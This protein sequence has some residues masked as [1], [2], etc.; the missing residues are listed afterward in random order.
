M[1]NHRLETRRLAAL[2]LALSIGAAA[3][4]AQTPAFTYQ[5]KLTDGGNPA[6]GTF[7]LQF[8][9]FDALNGGAQQGVTLTR[10]DVIVTSGVFTVQLDFGAAAFPGA[11]RFLEIGVRPGASTGAFTVLTPRQ[12]VL[13]TPYALR[14]LTAGSADALAVTCIGCVTGTQIG[15]GSGN[16][17]QNT[18]TPQPGSDFNIS[19]TGT[20]N[21]FNATTQFNLNN[22]RVL[23][24]AGTANLFVGAGAGVVNTSGASNTFVGANAGANNT[25]GNLNTFFGRSVG[26]SNTSGASNSFFASSAGTANTTGR[27]GDT[28]TMGSNN[29]IIG[30]A[31]DVGSNNLSNAT[32]IGAQAQVTTDNSLVLGSIN[33][34]NGATANTKVGIGTT[35]PVAPLEVAA[36]GTTNTLFLTN[37]GGTTAI[38]MRQAN[39]TRSTPTAT[40]ESDNLLQLEGRGHNGNGFS[41]LGRAAILFQAAEDWTN[42]ANGARI[43]FLI[44]PNGGLSTFTA[45]RIDQDGQVG[46]G[47]LAPADKLDVNGDIRVGTS[48]TNGCLKNNNGGAIIGA[49]SSDL[50]FKQNITAFPRILNN[51]VQLRPVHYYWRAAE[52]P[53]KH[54]GLEQSYG[55]IAQEVEQVLPELVSL[56][57][58][59]YR[60]VDYSKLPLLTI[61][62]V[63]DLKVENEALKRRLLELEKR[64]GVRRTRQR[65]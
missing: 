62:A 21:I 51:F 33:G 7:D 17:I 58:Q 55:L 39:G 65:R 31:A 20:A 4:V 14:S 56:D 8:T 45:M 19:G 48:G 64:I 26:N 54:F 27:A 30:A 15:A 42:A 47:D 18:T 49:C 10:E 11:A 34:V 16:Y 37:F 12:Q 40:L 3:S 36:E 32:A 59:G 52:F 25:T 28:N 44:T 61:Q 46:L 38:T 29:T 41:G 24:N 53:D 6:N 43:D 2:L 5:G 60:Q 23:S 9:L 57:A 13:T 50:R 35:A 22:A 1:F 63:K